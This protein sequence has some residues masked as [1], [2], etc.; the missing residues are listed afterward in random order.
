MP[1]KN[2][3]EVLYRF[4]ILTYHLKRQDV[5]FNW[6]YPHLKK[7]TSKGSYFMFLDGQNM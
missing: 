7:E 3:V 1:A 4:I 2:F 5:H 6:T